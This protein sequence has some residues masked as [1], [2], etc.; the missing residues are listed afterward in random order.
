MSSIFIAFLVWLQFIPIFKM[1]MRPKLRK[2]TCSASLYFY[3]KVFNF[4]QFL[5]PVKFLNKLYY[6]TLST[7]LTLSTI[8]P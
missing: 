1:R 8:A 4:S 5:T 7:T 3:L 2:I 6:L